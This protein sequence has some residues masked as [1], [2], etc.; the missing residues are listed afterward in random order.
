MSKAQI[1]IISGIVAVLLLIFSCADPVTTPGPSGNDDTTAPVIT[2]IG[3]SSIVLNEGDTYVE[4]GA[5][6]SDNVDGDISANIVIDN[7]SVN[8]A[9][10]AMYFVSY[11]VSDAAGNNALEVLR[12]VTV[13]SVSTAVPLQ[14]NG[15]VDMG[16]S[17]VN[18]QINFG[19]WAPGTPAGDA[20]NDG[21]D[22]SITLFETVFSLDTNADPDTLIANKVDSIPDASGIP[23][24]PLVVINGTAIADTD[25]FVWVRGVNTNGNGPW[26]NKATVR[27]ADPSTPPPGPVGFVVN[28]TT[29]EGAVFVACGAP[30]AGTTYR[31]FYATTAAAAGFT[32]PKTEA[33]E[34]AW[35]T[36][37]GD[38]GGSGPFG[39]NLEGLAPSTDYTVFLYQ[40]NGILF[41]SDYGQANEV[42]GVEITDFTALNSAITAAQSLHDAAVEG[43]NP[44]EYA[45]GSKAVYQ[46][47][48]DAAQLVA[49]DTLADQATVDAAV[50]DLATATAVFQSGMVALPSYG[51]YSET[52]SGFTVD[53]DGL[54][55]QWN[56]SGMV[57]DIADTAQVLEGSEAI[58]ITYNGSAGGGGIFMFFSTTLNEAAKT[59]TNLLGYNNLVFSIQATSPLSN[60]EIKIE[61]GGGVTSLYIADYTPVSAGSWDTYTIPLMDFDG[62]NFATVTV[63]FSAWHPNGYGSNYDGVIYIDNVFFE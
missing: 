37:V 28:A 7:S 31:L 56:D 54:F 44:G 34:Y 42:S 9:V 12:T 25:Y 5:T 50:T 38:G 48:I 55:G 52:F 13:Q 14:I 8:T 30:S 57:Y 58:S 29:V 26:S 2:L 59:E 53:V 43:T 17:A 46:S 3:D 62:V 16:S 19:A 24:F 49:D 10:P 11:N 41:S 20:N 27:T 51:L 6:A 60:L 36:Y 45:A 61:S 15:V 40:Y 39:F 4:L 23:T 21:W 1:K 18:L 22:E 47:A 63:P 33:T 35:G 32:D